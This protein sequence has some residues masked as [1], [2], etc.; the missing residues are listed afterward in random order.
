MKKENWG[1]TFCIVLSLSAWSL[2]AQDIYLTPFKKINVGDKEIA[3]I[4]FSSDALSFAAADIKGIVSLQSVATGDSQGKIAGTAPALLHDFI[5][6][7]KT[8][9]LLDNAGRLTKFN[10]E[11]KESTFAAF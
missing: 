7:N 8:F 1:F 3:S 9:L 11:N 2:S 5:N 6:D 10:T 4:S